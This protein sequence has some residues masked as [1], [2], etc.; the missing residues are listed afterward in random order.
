MKKASIKSNLFELASICSAILIVISIV[1]TYLH[2]EI[3]NVIPD[4]KFR[5]I[6][7]KLNILWSIESGKLNEDNAP[8]GLNVDIT[9]DEWRRLQK[10]FEPT[11]ASNQE[12][13]FAYGLFLI[14]SLSAILQFVAY[15][16]RHSVTDREKEL[17]KHAVKEVLGKD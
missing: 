5:V 6:N 1:V 11:K 17:I 2:G 7:E 15:F 10:S 9:K 8:P 4:A 16:Q 12:S 3:A 14:L 13:W